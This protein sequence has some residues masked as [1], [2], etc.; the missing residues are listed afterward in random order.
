MQISQLDILISVVVLGFA[1]QFALMRMVWVAINHRFDK[2]DDRLDKI[3]EKITD[4]DR[5]LCRLEG[6]FS[7][8]ECCILNQKENKEAQ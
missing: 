5:R 3:D 2:T 8:K 4:I 1:V 6:A 7:S